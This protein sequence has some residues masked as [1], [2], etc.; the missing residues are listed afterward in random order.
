MPPVSERAPRPW[1][2]SRRPGLAAS[3]GEST[4]CVWA[5]GIGQAASEWG[6]GSLAASRSSLQTDAA[7]TAPPL[8]R[9]IFSASRSDASRFPF[10][11]SLSQEALVG[12]SPSAT[13]HCASDSL[14]AARC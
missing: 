2:T 8:Q 14:S 4:R 12:L 7:E 10:S 13:A 5:S 9:S 6:R 1:G 11:I 3:A